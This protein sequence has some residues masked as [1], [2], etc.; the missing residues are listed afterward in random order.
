MLSLSNFWLI[1][2][3]PLYW[4]IFVSHRWLPVLVIFSNSNSNWITRRTLLLCKTLLPN[5]FWGFC[6]RRNFFVCFVFKWIESG[7]FY[8]Y[9][10]ISN[11]YLL[12]KF[13]TFSTFP[14]HLNEVKKKICDKLV[15]TSYEDGWLKYRI[16]GFWTDRTSCWSNVNFNQNFNPVWSFPIEMI[17]MVMMFFLFEE[18]WMINSGFQKKLKI[19]IFKVWWGCWS[20]DFKIRELFF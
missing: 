16:N 6:S 8:F 4:T 1:L 14:A 13:Q 5:D 12:S 15:W 20:S 2:E 3:P 11:N 7:K 9:N 10:N 18:N 19:K 17:S